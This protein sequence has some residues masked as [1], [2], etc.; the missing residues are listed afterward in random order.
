MKNWGTQAKAEDVVGQYYFFF[1]TP[2]VV[3]LQ[4]NGLYFGFSI[5][6]IS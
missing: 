3:G 4:C 6:Y 2:H 5:L 1:A